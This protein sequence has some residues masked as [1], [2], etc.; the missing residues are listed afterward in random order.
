[1]NHP[2]SAIALED[3]ARQLGI[4]VSTVSRALRDMPGI[5]PATRARVMEQAHV[6][7]YIPPRKKQNEAPSHPRNILMLTSGATE[8]PAGYLAGMSQ[9]ALSLNFSLLSHVSSEAE[10]LNILNP[11]YQP[12]SLRLGL[13]SGILLIYKWPDEVVDA[14]SR[15]LPTVSIVEHYPTLPIDVIGIDH[16]GGM[17][18][19][20]QHLQQAGH[21]RI[22]FLGLHPEISWVRSRFAA[23]A[24][25]MLAFGLPFNLDDVV[26]VTDKR[27][28]FSARAQEDEAATGKVAEKIT[29]GIRAWVCASDIA[30][31]WLCSGLLKRGLQIP[32]DVAVTGFHRRQTPAPH[33]PRLTTTEVRDNLVGAAALRRLAYRLDNPGDTPRQI[34][35][36]CEFF[37]GETTFPTPKP[38]S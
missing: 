29:Q 2:E 37:Q 7:G 10:A 14:L 38:H 31:N 26:P 6:L 9:V 25:T 27:A 21:R 11:K 15:K 18:S 16:I 1:M 5:H 17:F 19:L 20:V 30:A 28:V 13:V 4:A 36:P 32:D 22:G 8:A 24:E 23:Y 34:L 35:L 12:P 3:I 33:L